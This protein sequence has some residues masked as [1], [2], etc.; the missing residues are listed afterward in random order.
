M[1][2]WPCSAISLGLNFLVCE[3]AL[4][5]LY[6]GN[7]NS[8]ILTQCWIDTVLRVYCHYVAPRALIGFETA[9]PGV[10]EALMRNTKHHTNSHLR[11]LGKWGVETVGKRL[12]WASI[13]RPHKGFEIVLQWSVLAKLS[14]SMKA[15]ASWWLPVPNALD[16]ALSRFA[17]LPCWPHLSSKQ[18]AVA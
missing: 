17:R 6:Q 10:V 15:L 16:T 8:V 5:T 11:I 14:A 1:C 2:P 7:E 9:D 18:D 4:S 13:P 12:T 3:M